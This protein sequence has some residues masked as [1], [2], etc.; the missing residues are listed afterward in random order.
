MDTLK[1]I[2]I[3]AVSKTVVEFTELGQTEQLASRWSFLIEKNLVRVAMAAKLDLVWCKKCGKFRHL[4]LECDVSDALVS[5]LFKKSFKRNT[6]NVNHLQL[7]S[8]YAKKNLGSGSGYGF[9]PSGALDLSGGSP[10]VLTNNLFL[11]AHLA[12]LECSLELLND[13]ISGI[14]HKIS[15]IE[16]MPLASS[17][18]SDHLVFLINTNLDLNSDMILDGSV[19]VSISFSVVLA[20]GSNVVNSGAGFD[21]IYSAL[22]DARKFYHAAKLAVF[23]R[24][25]EANIRSAINRRMKSFKIDKGH[26][27]R[28]VLK[29][30]F[31]KVLLDHLVVDNELILEPDLVGSGSL[32]VYTDKSLK[33]LR[34]VG[35]KA[36]AATFF[37]DI[38]LGLGV[39][40]LDLML[41]TMTELQVIVLA[42]ECVSL[43]SSVHLFLNSQSALN[44]C[45]SELGLVY[46]DFHNQYWVEY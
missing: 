6:S 36:G 35:Y 42:L 24:A 5:A 43:S 2:I 3:I 20:L 45:K 31:H 14:V 23:L 19:V 28:S 27:I 9:S 41:S 33:D 18:S 10:L 29:H 8:L 15:G 25:K 26:T 1:E 4:V 37:E 16:L 12:L 7:A 17:L 21:Y 32:F 34:T 38:N 13:K 44:T 39:G 46:P 22:F 11:S 30:P 40:V